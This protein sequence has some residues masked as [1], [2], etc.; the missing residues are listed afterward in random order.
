MEIIWEIM[1]D[2]YVFGPDW[3]QERHLI[4]MNN[5]NEFDLVDMIRTHCVD[6]HD[7][8]VIL[9]GAKMLGVVTESHAAAWVPIKVSV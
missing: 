4:K 2:K 5:A 8:E 6:E 9:V 1:L 3:I 7:E